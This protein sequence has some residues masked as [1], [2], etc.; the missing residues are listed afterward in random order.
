MGL[1]AEY[2]DERALAVGTLAETQAGVDD[3]GVVVRKRYAV[4]LRRWDRAPY[5]RRFENSILGKFSYNNFIITMAF[6]QIK[7]L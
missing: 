7:D 2:L 6:S 4:F 5:L 3:A 1:E